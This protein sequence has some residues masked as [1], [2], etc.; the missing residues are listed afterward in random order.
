[1]T[2]LVSKLVVP[3]D[4]ISFSLVCGIAFFEFSVR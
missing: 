3:I 2:P 4:G 1:M